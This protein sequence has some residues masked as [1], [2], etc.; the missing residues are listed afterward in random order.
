LLLVTGVAMALVVHKVRVFQRQDPPRGSFGRAALALTVGAVGILAVALAANLFGWVQLSGMLTEA[1]VASFFSAFGWAVIVA[2][3][4]ALSP[5]AVGDVLGRAFPSLRR[6][7]EA[8]TRVIVRVAFSVAL[9]MWLRATLARFQA[10]DPLLDALG[11]IGA[12]E[13][14]IGGLTIDVGGLFGGIV[15]IAAT[16]LFARLLRFFL[17]EEVVPRLRLRR[18]SAQSMVSLANYVVWG[19]GITM[20]ASAAGLTGTQL[21]VVVGAL[22]VGIGF[23]LQTI[24]NNFVSGLILI[25]ERP[26]KVGDTVQTPS[27]YGRVERIGIRASVIRSFE[28]AEIIVPNGDL[29]SREVTNWTGTDEL[30][31]AEV[32]VGVEYGTDPERVI[33]VLLRVAREQPKALADPEPQAQMIRFGESSLDFRL[34][35]WTPIA[36]SI[37]LSSELHVAINRELQ[38]AGITIPFPQRDLHIKGSAAEGELDLSST[39][40]SASDPG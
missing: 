1:I 19:L 25:F 13:F 14:S 4:A 31:R 17:R 5:V 12:S 9:L 3:T 2:S 18:G 21:A 27:F 37:D 39:R 7:K 23:G 36:D 26:I 8:V 15:L 34:R 11:R 22:S 24:V 16:W 10:R 33:E 30:R 38:A 6:E 32:I 28:G 35:C 20:A 40:G 29:I